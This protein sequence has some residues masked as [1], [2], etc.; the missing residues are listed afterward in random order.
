MAH[1]S[2]WQVVLAQC[3][4]QWHLTIAIQVK[5][6]L[7]FQSHWWCRERHLVEIVSVNCS[8]LQWDV[9]EAWTMKYTTCVLTCLFLFCLFFSLNY[10]LEIPCNDCD[11]LCHVCNTN[12][13]CSKLRQCSVIR[14]A[15]IWTIRFVTGR[16][17]VF[18]VMRFFCLNQSLKQSYQ[19]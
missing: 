6:P 2:V 13:S 8:T 17:F 12:T 11:V 7:R 18:S 10:R 3:L 19:R 4:K 5:F 1:C 15:G 9:P 16:L 14:L